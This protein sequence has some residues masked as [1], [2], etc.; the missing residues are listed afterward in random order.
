MEHTSPS[1]GPKKPFGAGA[2][3]S[4]LGV[5]LA[6]LPALVTLIYISTF[7]S[8]RN[9]R[10]QEALITANVLSQRAALIETDH[11]HLVDKI[12]TALSKAQKNEID[13]ELRLSIPEAQSWQIV[14]LGEMGVASLLPADYGLESLV[15]L[16]RVRQTFNTGDTSFEVVRKNGR[17]VLALVS[18]YDLDSQ[19]GVAIVMFSDAL[20]DRWVSTSSA[21][22]FSL[23]Q[24]IENTPGNLIAGPDSELL[25]SSTIKISNT[26]WS[27]SFSPSPN[28]E[29]KNL[30]LSP[31]LWLLTLA[32]LCGAIWLCILEPRQRLGQDVKRILTA[33]DN[34]KPVALDYPEL[35]PVVEAVRQLS[36]NHRLRQKRATSEPEAQIRNVDDAAA[37]EPPE[38]R[39]NTAWT[40]SEGSWITLPPISSSDE[41]NAINELARGLANLSLKG[42][43]RSYAISALGD[44]SALA[45]KTQLS[46]ALLSYG[47]DVVDLSS[48]P[49]PVVH[50]A[51]HNPTT[52]GAAL[53]VKRDDASTLWVG[54]LVNRSWVASGF[55][56]NVLSASVGTETMSG[57]GRIVKFSLEQEY[58]DR[59]ADD[60]A[61]ADSI[62]L[63]VASNDGPTLDLCK[64]GLPSM[65]CDIVS[66]RC[67]FE[68]ASSQMKEWL[69]DSNSDAGF[70]IDANTSQLTVFDE[71]GNRILDDHVLMLII[72]DSL[73]RHPGSDVLLG[74]RSSRTLPAF[75]T[76]CGGASSVSASTPQVIQGEMQSKGVL[77]AGD[78]Q[79]AIFIR[80]RWLG[81][82]DPLY[83]TARLAEIVSNADTK[84]SA[85]VEALP[86]IATSVFRLLEAEDLHEALFNLLRDHSN[87]P[88]A[89]ITLTEGVRLDFADSGLHLEPI[90]ADGSASLRFEGDDVECRQRLERLLADILARKHPDLVLPLP[91]HDSNQ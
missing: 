47:V 4:G 54:A 58:C 43:N 39:H 66:H 86:T 57:D 56:Q 42:A 59:L 91:Q 64:Q 75:V 33:A 25:S 41:A 82:N 52:S 7:F 50:M 1:R 69:S 34:Q 51:T 73:A 80:D 79:G 70:F 87:F 35:A 27:L 23:W 36:L 65:L 60:I 32:G 19:Q 9:E 26:D 38:L 55:W 76:R 74:P 22:A 84:L 16:D 30:S 14:P 40:V 15:L 28:L 6:V 24:S 77:L 18:R 44:G 68:D 88:G 62:Q 11:D 31:M 48:A 21:G 10:A 37:E 8:G 2:K 12:E 72:Q 45:P 13:V 20:I 90:D 63:L 3:R 78:S 61:M 67:S 53:V 89:R 29:T 46:K 49:L 71:T 85:L 83:N 81:S 17:I 5:L